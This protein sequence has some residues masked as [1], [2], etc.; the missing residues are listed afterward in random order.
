MCT[1][2]V[3]ICFAPLQ[4]SQHRW[5]INPNCI[6]N[7]RITR[8]ENNFVKKISLLWCRTR[9]L[10]V[11]LFKTLFWGAHYVF[12]S[13]SPF[14]VGSG[15]LLINRLC[16]NFMSKTLKQS[17]AVLM[18]FSCMYYMEKRLIWTFYEFSSNVLIKMCLIETVWPIC[19]S[20]LVHIAD[21]YNVTGPCILLNGESLAHVAFSL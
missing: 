19:V 8:A 18:G 4:E 7:V 17:N 21:V 3:I 14:M 2:T 9:Y 11:D 5:V 12:L 10:S 13:F 20:S 16:F 1:W 15:I 6:Y